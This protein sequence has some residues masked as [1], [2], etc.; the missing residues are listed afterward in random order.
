MESRLEVSVEDVGFTAG[1]TARCSDI[2]RARQMSA[3]LWA[4]PFDMQLI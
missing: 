4:F 1:G 2:E 3:I